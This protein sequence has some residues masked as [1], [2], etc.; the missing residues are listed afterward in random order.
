MVAFLE[1]LGE[2][3]ETHRLTGDLWVHPGRLR[4]MGELKGGVCWWKL[5]FSFD[6]E[7]RRG[8]FLDSLGVVFFCR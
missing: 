2:A 3:A 4:F 6:F 8:C 7:R 5:S 1:F